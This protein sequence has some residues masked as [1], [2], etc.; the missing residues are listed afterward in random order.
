MPC[1]D[2]AWVSVDIRLPN[3]VFKCCRGFAASKTKRIT[4]VKG[5]FAQVRKYCSF[6][7]Y[8]TV[9]PLSLKRA[10]EVGN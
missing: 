1:K 6:L 5:Y 10:M 9:M 8:S 2:V 7:Q 3:L 4:L